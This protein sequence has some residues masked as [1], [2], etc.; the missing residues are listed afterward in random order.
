M[1]DKNVAA[2]ISLVYNHHRRDMVSRLMEIQHD[3]QKLIISTQHIHLD[4]DNCLEIIATKG[5]ARDIVKLTHMLK[6]VKGIKHAAFTATT[7]GK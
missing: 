5:R 1:K 2:V 4:H 7:S 6:G 3:F